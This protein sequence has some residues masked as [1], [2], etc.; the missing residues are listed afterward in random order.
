MC[1][2][3]MVRVRN[4]KTRSERHDERISKGKVIMIFQTRENAMIEISE[5]QFVNLMAVRK[6]LYLSIYPTPFSP[7][8]LSLSL[9]HSL[10]IYIYIALSL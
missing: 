1:I 7:S 6:S 5:A 10:C 4:F 9:T 3:R 2:N 8:P